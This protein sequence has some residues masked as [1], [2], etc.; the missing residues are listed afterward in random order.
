MY[1]FLQK[2]DYSLPG[3][4]LARC[5]TLISRLP[6]RAVLLFLQ[7]NSNPVHYDA[8]VYNCAKSGLPPSSYQS[9]LWKVVFPPSVLCT[10]GR[11]AIA[12]ALCL[13]NACL[14]DQEPFS[15]WATSSPCG[16]VAVSGLPKGCILSFGWES[17]PAINSSFRAELPW[18]MSLVPLDMFPAIAVSQKTVLT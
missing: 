13:L 11:A 2:C 16:F 4:D 18:Y 5:P 3:L 10:P 9:F 14:Q 1:V 15:L 17:S 7:G 8:R 12:L 6:A